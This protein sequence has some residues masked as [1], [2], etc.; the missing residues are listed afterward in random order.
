M[1]HGVVHI[2]SFVEPNFGENA[3]VVDTGPDGVAWVID[4][5]LPP[6]PEEIL[7]HMGRRRVRPVAIVLTHGHADHIAGVP[8][9][10][11]AF[12]RLPIH[13]AAAE[14]MLLTNPVLNLSMLGGF[15]VR[16]DAD[17]HHD[18]EPPGPIALGSTSW[19]IFDVSGHSLAGRA[20]YCAEAGAVI[21]GDALFQG[22][23]GRTDFPGSDHEKLLR[24][25]RAHLFT[26]PDNTRV[27]SGHGPV[28]TIGVEKRTNPFLS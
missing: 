10:L 24:N 28:T 6:S 4:P 26:L 27:Y 15:P 3:Y 23:I 25:I 2:E 20:L 19:D 12:P 17:E 5:G 18:L 13:M 7:D 21:V 9:I 14:R 22:S 16:V 1:N 11:R 8:E